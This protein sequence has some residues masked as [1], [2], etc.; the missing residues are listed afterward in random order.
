MAQKEKTEAGILYRDEDF[1]SKN[2][3][4]RLWKHRRWTMSLFMVFSDLLCLFLSTGLALVLWYQVRKDFLSESYAVVLIPIAIGFIATY[5][6]LGLYP[7]I[8]LGPV[9]ELRRS[10]IG[11]FLVVLGLVT[12]SFYLGTAGSWSRAILGLSWLFMTVGIPLFRKVFRRLA[13]KLKLWG[14]PVVIIGD[15]INARAIY[16]KLRHRPLTGFWPVLCVT[17]NSIYKI[18]PEATE[19]VPGKRSGESLFKGINIAIITLGEA[20]LGDAKNILLNKAHEFQ[21]I[22]VMLDEQQ[23]GP[24]WVTPL[25][26]VDHLGLEVT[27]NLLNPL[28]KA[29][30]RLFDLALIALSVPFWI[31]FFILVG[32]LIKLDSAGPVFY[33]QKRIGY[34]G[35][36]IKIWKFRSMT[37]NAENELET[38]LNENPSLKLEWEQ[39]F[40]LKNDPRVTR[41]GNILRRTSL[42]EFPQLWNVLRGEMSLIG[43]RPIVQ[44]EIPLYSDG[45][46][47]Y[48]QV[49]PGLTGMWQISGRNDIPY[50]ER[51]NLDV[52]YVQNWS[53]WLDIHILIHTFVTVSAGRGAY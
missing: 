12:L 30:K 13:S 45:F 4:S 24:L 9:E 5:F 31:P 40:K 17:T 16:K 2:G 6:L 10:T 37:S 23:V 53:I 43:P 34:D 51:V 41:F 11:S 27:H 8:G 52:Y 20:S 3:S 14:M 26:L 15:P 18:L 35:K 1:Y 47:I 21:R 29:V 22:I 50:Q 49:L 28:Q 19:Q 44:D 7:A 39:N 48:K 38:F 25:Y 46:S 36:E 32:I 33:S 42:D